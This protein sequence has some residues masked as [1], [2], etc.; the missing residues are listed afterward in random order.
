MRSSIAWFQLLFLLVVP[1]HAMAP[2]PLTS[3]SQI[4]SLS[5]GQ[6]NQGLPVAFEATVT[7]YDPGLFGLWVQQDGQAIY[8]ETGTAIRLVPGDRVMIRG[9]TQA[10]FRPIVM[11]NDVTLLGSGTSPEPEA[12]SFADLISGDHD[13]LRVTIRATVRAADLSRYANRRVID[14]QL[15]MDGG[16]IETLVPS[17]DASAPSDLLD[18]EVEVTGVVSGRFDGKKQLTGAALYVDSLSDIRILKRPGV[19]PQALPVTPMDQVL[20]GYRVQ[21]M[22]QRIRVQ[23]TITYYQPGSTVVLENGAKSLLLMTQ[24]QQPLRVG[25][26]ADASGFP[27]S[28]LG[29]L[30]LTHSEIRSAGSQA[31]IAPRSVTL[32]DLRSGSAAFDLVSTEGRL[33]MAVQE[34]S[35]DEYVL[36]SGGHLFSAIYRHPA[37]A[38]ESQFRS[39][40]HIPFGSEVRVTGICMLNGSDPFDK[41]K[42]VDLLLRSPADVL[43]VAPPSVLNVQNLIIVVGFLLIAVIVACLWGWA[44]SRKINRQVE[45]M[46]RRVEAEAA[47]EKRRSSILEDINGARP[48]SEIIEEISLLVSLKLGGAHCWCELGANVRLGSGNPTPAGWKVLS[49]EVCSRSGSVHGTLFAAV[50]PLAPA[51]ADAME[52]LSIGSWLATVAIETRGLYSDLMHRSEYDLLTDIYN[53]FSLERQLDALIEQASPRQRPFGLIYIDLDDFKPVNDTYGHQVGDLYLQQC[54][55]RMRNQLRPGDLMARMGGDEFAALIPNIRNRADAEE[56]AQRL[57][58]CF[59]DPFTLQGYALRGSASVGI[60]VYPEDGATSDSLLSAADAAMY[61]VKNVKR[62]NEPKPDGEARIDSVSHD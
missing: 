6:A 15:L 59:E 1:T 2:K 47:L 39:I 19:G 32:S 27:D 42:D 4:H 40:R 62:A 54:V 28:S 34:A 16:Y 26:F 55:L 53:R 37:N 9:T 17:A 14:L 13:C 45:A 33:L 61:V 50:N 22:T 35:E 3:L 31:P 48:L 56:I 5:N 38:A 36:V 18:D 57:D 46:A 25:D 52:A 30:T 12:V 23:G 60:A 29:Y 43:L 51:R 20:K 24:T 11:S 58:R 41:S 8:V 44:L 49:H 10:S 7:Y 21:D